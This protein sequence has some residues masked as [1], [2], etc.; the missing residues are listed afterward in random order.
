MERTR[1]RALKKVRGLKHLPYEDRL[2]ELGLFSLEKQ[3]LWSDQIAAFEYLKE[4]YKQEG[5]RLFA[6]VDNVRT[7]GSGFKLREGRF[8]LD[9]RGKYYESGEVLEQAAQ[10]VCG[11]PIPESVHD[12]VG[13]SP[14]QPGLVLDMEIGGPACGGGLKL[15]DH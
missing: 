13:W 3:R 5:I 10:R 11:Y 8:R 15:H 9:M 12:Q 7:K 4:A 14:G 1:R 2:R 6:R